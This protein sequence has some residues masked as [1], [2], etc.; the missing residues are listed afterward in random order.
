[1][2]V[3]QLIITD[4]PPGKGVDPN[5]D[6]GY[7][8]AAR[9]SGIDAE[10]YRLLKPICAHCGDV[11]Y[12]SPASSEARKRQQ[13]WYDAITDPNAA[14]VV[15]EKILN[16][17]PPAWVYVRLKEDLFALV[18]V[19]YVGFSYDN[20]FGNFLAH[21]LVF[22]AETL[23]SCGH[24]PL[25]LVRSDLFRSRDEVDLTTLPAL[26]ALPRLVEPA[27]S[28][29]WLRSPYR[30]C[31]L[32]VASALCTVRN[33]GQ[34]LYLCLSE[35]Q[36]AVPLMESLLDLL[37]PSARCRTPFCTYYVGPAQTRA[38]SGGTEGSKTETSAYDML[39]VCGDSN[40]PSLG[41]MP[42]SYEAGSKHAVFNF[43]ES[44]FTDVGQ[45]TAYASF[46]V[47][48]AQN[49]RRDRL[50][51]HHA[52]AEQLG[53]GNEH[54]AWDGLITLVE[55][56]EPTMAFE[57]VRAAVE[58]LERLVT[59]P[60]QVAAALGL[61]SPHVRRLAE[62]SNVGAL[63][64]LAPS[65]AALVDRAGPEVRP[66]PFLAEVEEMAAKALDGGSPR[67]AAALLRACG[68][69]SGGLLLA[70]VRDRLRAPEG[71]QVAPATAEERT[72]LVDLLLEGLQLAG[73]QEANVPF[74]RLLV[75]VFHAAAQISRLP[76]VWERIGE[77]IVKPFFESDLSGEKQQALR[78]IIAE[79]P[80]AECPQAS[81]W[82]SM[83]SLEASKPTGE[84]L[85]RQLEN[86]AES[87]AHAA[88]DDKAFNKVLR[89][90]QES[91]QEPPRRAFALGRMSEKTANTPVG[92]NLYAQYRL[93]IES[94]PVDRI[95]L[96]RALAKA[97]VA[98]VLCR[99]MLGS[100]RILPW[101][102]PESRKAFDVW[103]TSILKPFPT[104]FD[105][106]CGGVAQRLGQSERLEAVLP[107]AKQLI[108]RRS[109]AAGPGLV[110]LFGALVSALPMK[111][112]S[113]EN[114]ML[115]ASPPD[116]LDPGAKARLAV[117]SFLAAVKDVA[118]KNAWSVTEFRHSDP[119]W[120]C[121][122]QLDDQDKTEALDWCLDTF[123]A[124]GIIAP[125][126]AESLHCMMEAIGKGQPK[127]VAEAAHHL[128]DG[129]DKV[130]AV[131]VAMAFAYGALA[132]T[133]QSLYWAEAFG[134]LVHKFDS[135]TRR[136]LEEHLRYR[137]TRG[138]VQYDKEMAHLCSCAKLA[139][140][141]PSAPLPPPSMMPVGQGE[142]SAHNMRRRGILARLAQWFR[143]GFRH[144]DDIPGA[145][146]IQDPSGPVKPM[147]AVYPTVPPTS[148]ARPQKKPK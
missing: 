55:L 59:Q 66:Q 13:E 124:T 107:L 32:P 99:D 83:R 11:V 29:P 71:F 144:E 91:L 1:M 141:K 78:G 136:L 75:A 40:V 120:H 93:V 56:R 111:P 74:D 44:R 51:G 72:Q 140:P 106:V 127:D 22:P 108:L 2:L 137:F 116:R 48:C 36:Q 146:R 92:D 63:N 123:S 85:Y 147:A 62:M 112:L 102:E 90:L 15:P 133:I 80:P 27:A 139:E 7:Q 52:I 94:Q 119:A 113:G 14:L 8:L 89:I 58:S 77:S 128:L 148:V 60:V 9:S 79:I 42:N 117:L 69:A 64:E 53:L 18:R 34:V 118:A 39:A 12:R 4:R 67:R 97:G 142:L 50:D 31:L 24:N 17:F 82:L 95:S 98:H 103:E 49:G 19:C 61:V 3:E 28:S 105:V 145:P 68:Q 131:Q 5:A 114:A 126:Q 129:R 143:G 122:A 115:L 6:R 104:V 54:V 101:Q 10:I 35:W 86:V 57:A 135:A 30:E 125:E 76:E 37:P 130:T 47:A 132:S 73:R 26:T 110:S 23:V 70:L 84:D 33:T 87:L 41:L 43:V 16:E 81:V 96:R 109:G 38:L 100:P 88:A 45:P 138:G 21:A 134:H 121:A 25:A 20:R 46:A 65:L